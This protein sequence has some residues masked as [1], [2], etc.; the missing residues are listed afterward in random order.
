M[1]I[2]SFIGLNYSQTQW[3]FQIRNLYSLTQ[4]MHLAF[5][6]ICIHYIFNDI[7]FVFCFNWTVSHMEIFYDFFNFQLNNRPL[8]F[9]ICNCLHDNGANPRCVEPWFLAPCVKRWLSEYSTSL[10]F[11]SPQMATRNLN[12][13]LIWILWKS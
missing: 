8:P 11:F 9:T 3:W 2:A 13:M 1:I 6:I 10:I 5:I 4:P 7:P 12:L